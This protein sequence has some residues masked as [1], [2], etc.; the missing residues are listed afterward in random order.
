MIIKLTEERAEDLFHFYMRERSSVPYYYPE[1]TYSE[2]YDSFFYDRDFDGRPLFK[3]LNTYVAMSG[4]KI[5]GFIQFGLSNFVFSDS[6]RDYTD[7]YGIIR[8]LY[9][10]AEVSD[11]EIGDSLA[12]AKVFFK[13]NGV[14][15]PYAFFHYFGMTCFSRQGKLH[16]SEFQ[17]EEILREAG[18]ELEHENVYYTKVLADV[19]V[20]KNETVKL[21]YSDD[22]TQVAFLDS[23]RDGDYVVAQAEL[24]Y[25]ERIN[26]VYLRWI[27]VMPEFRHQGYGSRCMRALCSSLLDRGFRLLET[28][29]ADSNV[30]AQHFYEKNGFRN[31]GIMR[32]YLIR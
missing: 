1:T 15:Q 30:T 28:D 21:K 4:G 31:R 10:S 16:Q 27:G 6:G 17:S 23:G 8:N 20:L 7:S 11:E 19:S 18:Y 25:L 13:E 32:S 24:T 26:L 29:T 22:M 5:R 9:F 2:W 12:I 3:E 14:E